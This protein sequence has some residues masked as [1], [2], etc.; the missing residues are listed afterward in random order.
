MTYRRILKGIAILLFMGT[1]AFAQPPMKA[2]QLDIFMGVELN[3]RDITFDRIY[4]FLINLTPGIK[5][6]MGKGWQAAA[7]VYI[8][9]YNDY[10]DYY[11]RVRVNMAVLSK[12]F[13]F[14]QRAALKI[15]GGWFGSERYGLDVKGQ[16]AA[17]EWLAFE[18]QTGLTGFCSMATS[19]QASKPKRWTALVGADI[20]LPKWNTELRGRGGRFI[21]TDYGVVGEAMR[22]F[23]H[24]TVG[25]YAQ[26][27]EYEH[28]N[29]GFKIIM[30]IPPYKR[31]RH[32]VNVRPAS[33]FRLT[34]NIEADP[35]SNK[36]YNTDPEENERDGWFDRE[37]FKWG[38]NTMES[39]FKYQEK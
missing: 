7:Q 33:N 10:G 21:Y 15:S 13:S 6:N 25:L 38:A 2:G 18:L 23:K 20:Y 30:M 4:D 31:K 29:G 24:C 12:Q 35:Y 19:W 28:W 9:V 37:A 16:Y 22:H 27:S 32:A 36:M 26:Y 11:K 34:Y 1:T 17:T 39:D 3:Y 5:W 14:Q 8:P